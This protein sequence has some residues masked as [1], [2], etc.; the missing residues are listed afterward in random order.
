LQFADGKTYCQIQYKLEIKPIRPIE[1]SEKCW[2]CEAFLS[3]WQIEKFINNV[4]DGVVYN[5]DSCLK[6]HTIPAYK[7]QGAIINFEVPPPKEEAS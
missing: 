7:E 2:D 1:H 4:S 3:E 6:E 5:C